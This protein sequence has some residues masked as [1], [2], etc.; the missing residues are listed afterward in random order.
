M[1]HRRT[2]GLHRNVAGNPLPPSTGPRATRARIPGK[3]WPLARPD[4]S[5][6]VTV[7]DRLIS[8]SR[9]T[10][11]AR[12]CALRANTDDETRRETNTKRS[13]EEVIAIAKN[14]N[15]RIAAEISWSR[16]YD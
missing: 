6:A 4:H 15:R 1:G 10:P 14:I 3:P 2:H 9:L 13:R 16:T 7:S 11:R 5:R 8:S 12:V